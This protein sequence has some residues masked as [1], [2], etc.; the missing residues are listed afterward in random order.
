MIEGDTAYTD[1]RRNA[2][3]GRRDWVAWVGRDGVKRSAPV[4]AAAVRAAMLATGTQGM[5]M[6]YSAG[7]GQGVLAFWSD[8]A[9]WL[10]HAKVGLVPA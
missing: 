9:R 2:R 5:F 8:G 7:D 3:Y 1:A 10:R 6:R 4:S